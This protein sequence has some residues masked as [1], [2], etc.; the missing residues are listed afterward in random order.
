L[1][2]SIEEKNWHTYLERSKILDVNYL[3]TMAR[4]TTVRR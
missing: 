2:L 1:K 4:V 3:L